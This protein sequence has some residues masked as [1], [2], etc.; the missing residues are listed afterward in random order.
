MARAGCRESEDSGAVGTIGYTTIMCCNVLNV[1]NVETFYIFCATSDINFG[2]VHDLDK[3]IS[4]TMFNKGKFF[5]A[6][7]M[8][9]T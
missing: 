9:F 4:E 2:W 6:H 5:K 3:N 8:A 1:Q 7:R